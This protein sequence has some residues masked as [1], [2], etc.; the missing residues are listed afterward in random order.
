MTIKNC[1]L[2]L[3]LAHLTLYPGNPSSASL[4][5]A[6]PHSSYHTIKIETDP[7]LYINVRVVIESPT[8]EK[9]THAFTQSPPL[10]PTLGALGVGMTL[11]YCGWQHTQ[12]DTRNNKIGG[13]IAMTTGALLT[14]A[15]L[16]VAWMHRIPTLV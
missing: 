13:Y 12:K 7:N 16:I 3:G 14:L 11:M 6:I 5:P 10:L 1:F 8:L 15:P 4:I 2:V 9:I